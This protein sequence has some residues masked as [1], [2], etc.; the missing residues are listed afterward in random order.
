MGVIPK[1]IGPLDREFEMV[2]GDCFFKLFLIFDVFRLNSVFKVGLTA[3]A[4]H[5]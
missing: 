2:I 5:F 4:P 1:T 3:A